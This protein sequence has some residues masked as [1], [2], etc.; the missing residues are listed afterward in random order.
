MVRDWRNASDR[1]PWRETLWRAVLR[2]H[3]TEPHFFRLS[4]RYGFDGFALQLAG[5]DDL[6]C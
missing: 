6:V 4:D 1:K 2:S 5:Y 3:A